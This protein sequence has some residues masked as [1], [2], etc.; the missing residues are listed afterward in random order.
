MTHVQ[1]WDL[2]YSTVAGDRP[3]VHAAGSG[4]E[5]TWMLRGSIH[6]VYA[7]RDIVQLAR[8]VAC[9]SA[10]EYA[11]ARGCGCHGDCKK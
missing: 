3:C 5:L 1:G 10:I 2:H 7:D 6:A 11:I 4:A 9:A 8:S